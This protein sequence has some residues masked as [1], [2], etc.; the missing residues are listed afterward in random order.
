MLRVSLSSS[1]QTHHFSVDGVNIMPTTST[2]TDLGIIVSN[3]L[4]WLDH[5]DHICIKAYRALNMIRRVLP[6]NSSTA[7][8]TVRIFSEISLDLLLPALAA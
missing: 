8:K 5:Y 1:T 3:N 6:A 4:S 7:L 2:H